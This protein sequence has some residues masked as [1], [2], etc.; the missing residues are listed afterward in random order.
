MLQQL[1]DG[2]P[3]RGSCPPQY[4]MQKINSSAISRSD[5]EFVQYIGFMTC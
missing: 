2:L 4:E 3:W 1:L 5:I